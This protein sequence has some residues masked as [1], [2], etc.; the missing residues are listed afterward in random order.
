MESFWNAEAHA[1][2]LAYLTLATVNQAMAAGA[3]FNLCNEDC[4]EFGVNLSIQTHPTEHWYD[5]RL[6]CLLRLHLGWDKLFRLEARCIVCEGIE[7][8]GL[9]GKFGSNTGLGLFMD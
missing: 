8:F 9:R 4:A 2:M 6:S 5:T 1:E 7:R 3:V